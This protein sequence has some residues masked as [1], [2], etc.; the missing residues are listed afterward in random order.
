[1]NWPI[2]QEGE[3]YLIQFSTFHG[4]EMKDSIDT[5][6]SAK[7]KEAVIKRIQEEQ[8]RAEKN[9]EE[10]LVLV[11]KYTAER[12]VYETEVSRTLASLKEK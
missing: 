10:L 12:L 1:M 2:L 5:I 4:D 6:P 7:G 9:K 11:F 3:N 8:E